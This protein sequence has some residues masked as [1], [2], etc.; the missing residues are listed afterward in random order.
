LHPCMQEE[1]GMALSRFPALVV[2]SMLV[3]A[4]AQAAC[5][6]PVPATDIAEA[7]LRALNHRFV[8]GTVDAGADLMETLTHDD[9][10]LTESDGSWRDR[11]EFVARMRRQA[12]LPNAAGEGME[13]RLF[14]PVA[15][16]H[17]AF[18][19]AAGH[20]SG[21]PARVRYTDVFVWNATVWQLVS[22]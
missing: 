7:Q 10:V 2:R 14:G 1:T 8:S 19:E 16:M 21:R 18:H 3:S 6:A 15:L 5:A 13:V 12:P 9:F 4:A 20:R 11:A 22:V 17:G